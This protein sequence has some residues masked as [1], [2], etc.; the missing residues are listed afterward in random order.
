M[1]RKSKIKV[2]G[3]KDLGIFKKLIVILIISTLA[4][5]MVGYSGI[6]AINKL[7]KGQEIIYEELLIPNQLFSALKSNVN[8]I[9][10]TILEIIAAP[11]MGTKQVLIKEIQSVFEENKELA[12]QIEKIYLQTDIK[13]KYEYMSQSMAE[14][15]EISSEVSDFA[16]ANKN[17]EVQSIYDDRID[18]ISDEYNQYLEEIEVLNAENAEAIYQS[19]KKEAQQTSIYL[20]IVIVVSII[21]SITVG[22]WISRLIVKPIKQ[23]QD[24][25]AQAEQGDFT[26]EGKYQAKDEIGQLTTSFNNM[27]TAVRAI[28]MTVRETSH[29][30]ASSSEQLGASS[31][32]SA[33]ASEHISQTIQQL[34][35]GANHQVDSLNASVEVIEAIADST[36]SISNNTEKVLSNAEKTA[37]LSVQG[38]QSVEKVS[39]KMESINESVTS[40]ADAFNGLK[41]RLYEIVNITGVITGIADQTNLLALNAAIEA[42]RAGEHGKGFAVVADEVRKL[43][44][45]SAQSATQISQLINIIQ[46]DTERTMD[47]VTT[48]TS[49]VQEGLGVVKE[50][51]TIFSNIK[52][53]IEN[54]V[55]QIDEVGDLVKQLSTGMK[56]VEYSIHGVKEIAA[57]T[58]NGS[59]TVTSATE[60]QLAS[61]EEITAS[62]QML[63][64]NAE[65]LQMII[66]QFKI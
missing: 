56:E 26:A 21:L 61:M 33:K 45:Q 44:E 64:D 62:A 14:L 37:Q 9:D 34:S 55:V 20:L 43:A 38:N 8:V 50:A 40:L 4:L 16:M 54:V 13:N 1:K 22:Y 36:E 63:S 23:L 35:E 15:E 2:K 5:G 31:E 52:G 57:G 65:M 11:D 59:H 39:E 7:S 53:S 49:E 25:F 27:I 47:N 41:G 24:A 29:Q 30:L 46:A 6:A 28:I 10:S 51:G 17:E 42:A 12:Q 60:E 19:D 3:I 18:P 32:E 58:A 48:A 66:S